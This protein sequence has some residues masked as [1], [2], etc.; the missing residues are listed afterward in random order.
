[1]TDNVSI[2]RLEGIDYL[3]AH[4]RESFYALA[5]IVKKNI[6]ETS[7]QRAGELVQNIELGLEK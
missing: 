2:L 4:D 1:M 3:A 5:Y 6:A 7:L